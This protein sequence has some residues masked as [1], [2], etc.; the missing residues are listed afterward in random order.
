M[1]CAAVTGCTV[2]PRPVSL[3]PR[4]PLGRDIEAPAPTSPG[5]TSPD[6]PAPRPTETLTLRDALALAL[7]G[8]PS[9]AAASWDIRAAEARTLQA[10]L[11]PNPELEAEVE[12]V[13]GE[14]ARSGV[15]AAEA[16]LVLS[17]AIELGGKRPKRV[18]V[19]ELEGELAGWDYEAQRLAVL[20]DAAKAFVEVL[21][22]QERAALAEQLARLAE[23]GHQTVAE[24]IKAGKESAVEGDKARV[25]LATSRI[26]RAQAQ[27]EL[28]ARRRA[29]AALWGAKTA[30]FGRVEGQLD[31]LA[32]VPPE[33]ALTG[34]L[35]DNPE[36][37]RWGTERRQ[38]EAKLV[39]ERAKATPDVTVSGGL[40]YFNEDD[41]GS[42]ILGLGLPLPLFDRNQG[43]IREA[44]AE[45]DKAREAQRAAEVR[46]HA[47]LAKAYQDLAAAHTE[48][49]TLQDEVLPAAERAFAAAQEG[50]RKGKFGYLEVLDAQRT[51]FEGRQRLIVALAAYHKAV[52]DVE[53]LIGRSL[54]SVT[55]ET[56]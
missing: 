48:A 20:T 24:K 21:A 35:A 45:R 5:P 16:G 56:Q 1:L 12:E 52:A 32:P 28:A 27:R 39:L 19:A 53:H 51:L 30:A 38:R 55:Q 13:A 17:Q 25:A 15:D 54:S 11:R 6:T 29:L 26:E 44:Q 41:G 9:L 40:Q 23:Q 8:N 49:S 34:F 3:P 4:R 18:R 42:F 7:L 50:Y 43:G 36:L 14:G 37:A 10:G 46:L 2:A 31:A 33:G 22:A 47:D